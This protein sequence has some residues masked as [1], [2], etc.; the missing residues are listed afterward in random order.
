MPWRHAQAWFTPCSSKGMVGGRTDLELAANGK[1]QRKQVER[2]EEARKKERERKREWESGRDQI[3][4]RDTET[5]CRTERSS[6]LF[7]LDTTGGGVT[8]R[9]G[10]FLSRS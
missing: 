7:E 5:R 1:R 10:F 4:S 8:Q 2:S 3:E 6:T 9:G